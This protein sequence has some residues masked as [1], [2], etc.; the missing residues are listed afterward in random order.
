MSPCSG[1]FAVSKDFAEGANG[2]AQS[3]QSSYDD[4][5][6]RHEEGSCKKDAARRDES[7]CHIGWN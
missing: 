7:S 2:E 1:T 4:Q 3:R 5:N 6:T